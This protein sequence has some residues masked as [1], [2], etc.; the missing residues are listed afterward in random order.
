MGKRS[1]TPALYELI[2]RGDRARESAAPEAEAPVPMRPKPEPRHSGSGLFE[3][4]RVIRVPVGYV[5]LCGALL[6]MLLI[7]AYIVGH[8][9]GESSAHEQIGREDAMQYG[10]GPQIQ[11]PLAQDQQQLPHRSPVIVG[12]ARPGATGPASGTGPIESDPRRAGLTYFYL[13]TT[14]RDGALQV[15]TFCREQGL[16]A[17]VVKYNN[18]RWRVAVLPGFV[19]ADRQ[20]SV[21]KNLEQKIWEVVR[22]WDTQ[23]NKGRLETSYIE[24]YEG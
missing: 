11:D 24:P 23:G 22:R 20:S 1:S 4:G 17:Y 13:I 6:L 9:I 15:A 12:G 2:N 16:E 21:I 3:P 8:G 7:S 14:T 18:Q 5:F 19:G 10:G